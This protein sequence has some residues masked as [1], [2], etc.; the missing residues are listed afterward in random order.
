MLR[1][2][3]KPSGGFLLD[4]EENVKKE[5]SWSEREAVDFQPFAINLNKQFTIKLVSHVRLNQGRW[6]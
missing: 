3:L 6:S 2:Q 1:L 5:W 4:D